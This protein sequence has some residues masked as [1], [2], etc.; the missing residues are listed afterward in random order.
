ML[1]FRSIP[2]T[3]FLV[4][5]MAINKIEINTGKLNTAIKILLLFALEAIPDIR[6]REAENPID[7]S[8]SA[9]TNNAVSLTGLKIK[10]ENKPYPANESR[11]H[12]KLL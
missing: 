10:I 11:V 7:V 3:A 6:L 4:I 1:A 12:N 8:A 5:L 9:E 2:S